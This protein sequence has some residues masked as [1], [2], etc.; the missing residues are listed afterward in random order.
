MARATL[1][2]TPEI[3][4]QSAE[5]SQEI[6]PELYE[7]AQAAPHL[8]HYLHILPIEEMGGPPTFVPK[9]QRGIK[10]R[11]VIYPVGDGI[12]IHIFDDPNDARNWYLAIEPV[13]L[14]DLDDVLRDL[15]FVLL[16]YVEDLTDTEDPA[17]RRQALTDL[18]ERVCIIEGGQ[19]RGNRRTGKR[20]RVS[21]EEFEALKYLVVR[22]KV[23]MGLLQPLILDPN[24][25]DISCS[26]V[27]GLFVEH[28]MFKSLKSSITFGDGEELDEFVL[29]LSERIK[30][31]VTFR[32][33][34]VDATLP[35]GSRINIVFG[36]DVSTRGSNFTIR[37]F[38]GV[39][40]SIVE[41]VSFGS[42][43]SVMAA[44]LWLVIGD[45]MNLF[46]SGE[47]A[48]GKT[49]LL[50][51]LTA[52]VEPSG[53]VVTLEDT[54]ELQVPHPNWTRE[55]TRDGS[56][57]EGTGVGMFDL[58]KAA[59]R[60]RPD[61]IMVGEIRGEE[62]AIA[63]QA[64]QTGHQVMSTFHAAT[65]EKLIQRITGNPIN[66]PK[67]YMDNLN[68]VAIQSAVRLGNGQTVRR[69]LSINEII[70][71]DA[72]SDSFSYIEVFHWNPVTDEF[73]FPGHKN[74]Y[75]LESRVAPKRGLPPHR[76]F[77]VYDEL[78]RRAEVLQKLGGQGVSNF[79]DVYNNLSRAERE[80]LV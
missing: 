46:V 35:D 55:L 8:W 1:P 68:V 36:K 48:S 32:R 64:M 13:L 6:S 63:F 49:T 3:R 7:A 27:G 59:L 25:E 65:V 17:V 57:G 11:N 69:V 4:Q 10:D 43:S 41:L 29:R 37:K 60:Q 42:I 77:E 20:V 39:P 40:M 22:D 12:F 51:A 18:L 75:L 61:A 19:V 54:S 38:A 2:F 44:Y 23:G 62:G 72:A 67:T 9:L 15:D 58:L 34:I 52:F 31:P 33:P 5:L 56:I 70:G 45:G 26:G 73:E 24:V 79:Y 50:N 14:S 30:K 71:Y 47:T 21:P 78:N 76:A 28:K 74:S 66:V 53:K 16:D 80:G